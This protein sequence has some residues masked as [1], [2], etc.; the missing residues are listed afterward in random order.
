[1]RRLIN[2]KK[3]DLFPI[4]EGARATCDELASLHF[5]APL[6]IDRLSDQVHFIP[7][8]KDENACISVQASGIDERD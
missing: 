6:L 4:V 5:E 8:E 7:Y 2:V 1:M 3:R